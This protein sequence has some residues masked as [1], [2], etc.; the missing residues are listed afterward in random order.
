MATTCLSLTATKLVQGSRNAWTQTC[1]FS[2]PGTP[3]DSLFGSMF[4]ETSQ[5]WLT[6]E[7][8]STEWS[9]TLRYE[10]LDSLTGNR[11]RLSVKRSQQGLV[12][13][14]VSCGQIQQLKEIASLLHILSP[15]GERIRWKGRYS[16]HGMLVRL[17]LASPVGSAG[18]EGSACPSP[19]TNDEEH[20]GLL[21][22]LRV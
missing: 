21:P 6:S 11:A 8:G 15:W 18:T 12:T 9:G 5:A 7:P 22:G 20:E 4:W 10:C 16:A 14:S 13:V 19:G 17:S 3:T 2:R 1:P